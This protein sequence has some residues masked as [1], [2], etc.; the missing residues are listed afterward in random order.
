MTELALNFDFSGAIVRTISK[1]L[2]DIWFI[3]KDVAIAL[4][5]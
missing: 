1:S 5:H 2:D 4:G 3:G